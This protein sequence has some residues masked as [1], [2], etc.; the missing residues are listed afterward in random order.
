MND[1]T[2]PNTTHT[3]YIGLG[4]N[5]GDV[6]SSMQKAL[7]FL[8]E[9]PCVEVSDISS[10][11][12]TPPWGYEDQPRFLNACA[13][14]ETSLTPIELLGL[15]LETEKKLNRI[16]SERWGPRT[17]DLDI[18]LYA[19]V[20]VETEALTIPHPRMGERAFVLV[21]LAEMVP[22]MMLNNLPISDWIAK[23]DTSQITKFD[24]KLNLPSL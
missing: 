19:D 12:E 2:A 3:A 17:L 11:Y 20:V 6:M 16:R 5:V 23:L 10:V 1:L 18:L 13:K 24:Q 14:L 4:G 7:A 8:Q 21:P 22:D 9:N 15:L